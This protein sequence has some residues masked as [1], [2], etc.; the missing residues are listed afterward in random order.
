MKIVI[1]VPTYNE[2]ENIERLVDV[3]QQNFKRIKH[4]IHILVVD[5]N[6]PD[7]TGQL[8]IKMQAIYNNLHLL[9][10][11]KK[12]LGTAYIRGIKFAISKLNADA[13]CEMDADFSHNPNDID[14]LLNEVDKGYDFV[15][16]SRYVKGGTVPKGVYAS[17]YV[18]NCLINTAITI[19]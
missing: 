1:V 14:R 4:V 7:G 2:R 15:I 19:S 9:E 18:I 16:G 17:Y 10:G 5:D 3:L 13:I 6:S 12:G 8:V 11:E